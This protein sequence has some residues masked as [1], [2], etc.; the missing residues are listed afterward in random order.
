MI[1]RRSTN[2]ILKAEKRLFAIGVALTALAPLLLHMNVH[3]THDTTRQLFGVR[4]SYNDKEQLGIRRR[5]LEQQ[6]SRKMIPQSKWS[7]LILAANQAEEDILDF[8]HGEPRSLQDGV[9]FGGTKDSVSI[10]ARRLADRIASCRQEKLGIQQNNQ[11][12]HNCMLRVVFLG[13]GQTTGRDIFYNQTYPFQAEEH[14]QAIAEAAG[15]QLEVLN[16]AMD[17]DLSK[18]GPQTA[19]MCIANLVGKAVDVIAW[20]FEAT[21][22][23]QP[24][25]QVEAFV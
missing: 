18:E 7:D 10:L 11:H 1:K 21:M 9:P 15:L 17:S 5:S 4:H 3:H 19:D 23:A 22:Q 6:Q 25:V 13:S 16:H 20:D 14:L 2:S 12:I 24:Q 8:F